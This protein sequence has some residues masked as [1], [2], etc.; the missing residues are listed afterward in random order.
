MRLKEN[1]LAIGTMKVLLGVK[2]VQV[3]DFTLPRMRQS[4]L[5]SVGFFILPSGLADLKYNVGWKGCKRG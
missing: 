5:V 4:E 2:N 3:I 1:C